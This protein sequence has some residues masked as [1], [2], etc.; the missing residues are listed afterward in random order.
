MFL[1]DKWKLNGTEKYETEIQVENWLHRATK[2][3]I[4]AVHSDIKRS[5]QK[6]KEWATSVRHRNALQGV[7]EI[8]NVDFNSLLKTAMSE[9]SKFSNSITHYFIKRE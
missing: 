4:W 9:N 1:P 7:T 2:C 5:I 3:S 8:L 6:Q